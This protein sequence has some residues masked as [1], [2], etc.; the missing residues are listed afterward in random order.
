[1]VVSVLLKRMREENDFDKLTPIFFSTSKPGQRL[2]LFNNKLPLILHNA[3]DLDTLKEIDIILSC[4]GNS[5]TLN[6]Y[7][8]LRM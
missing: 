2:F 6:I 3:Y 8:K 5:Y 1:M 4:Q 7:P